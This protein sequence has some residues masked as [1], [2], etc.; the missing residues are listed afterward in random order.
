MAKGIT[1]D[2]VSSA[3]DALVAAGEKPTVER[4]RT[5]LGTGSP[6]TVMR[7]LDIWR[8]ALAER[9]Q[10]ILKLP[11]VPTEVGQAFVELWRLAVTHADSLA[12]TALTQEQ[13]AL[14]AAQTSLLQERKVWEIALVE[15]QTLTQSAVKSREV[16]DTRLADVQ[17]LVDQQAGQ[18]VELT[19]QRDGL[20]QRVDQLVESY[21]THKN[22]VATER[23]DQAA[24]IRAVE[25]RAH[26]EIDRSRT[27]TKTLQARLDRAEREASATSVRLEKA[28]AGVREGAGHAARAK[29]LE[30]QLVRMDGLSSAL[31]NAQR[32][33]QAAEG[34]ETKLR[35]KLNKLN[36]A[37]PKA[38]PRKKRLLSKASPPTTAGR[39]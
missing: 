12:R 38:T 19:Q 37:G 39:N 28:M 31:V 6:N 34:R 10:D 16:A 24:H 5:Q 20:K 21:E 33:L 32:S 25:D 22:A 9:M 18:L 27:E 15:A 26:A 2:Q 36:A 1:Q 13:N 30:Q 14:L 35:E 29:T 4:V 17:R 3:A 8:V 11:E 23:E 7:M